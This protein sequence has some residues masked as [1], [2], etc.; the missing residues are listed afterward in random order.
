M[1]IIK[2]KRKLQ[3][4]LPWWLALSLALLKVRLLGTQGSE[5]LL[6]ELSASSLAS[7]AADCWL[8]HKAQP[9]LIYRDAQQGKL[10]YSKSLVDK[11]RL[12]PMWVYLYTNYLGTV[13]TVAKRHENTLAFRGAVLLR[14]DMPIGPLPCPPVLWHSLCRLHP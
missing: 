9:E 13:Y 6:G 5:Q 4:Y 1:E 3:F 2:E 11:A 8:Q 7:R 12:L 10:A 14:N